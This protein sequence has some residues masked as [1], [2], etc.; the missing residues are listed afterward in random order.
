M[1]VKADLLTEDFKRF[2]NYTHAAWA[3]KFQALVFSY[4]EEQDRTNER[5]RQDAAP[6]SRTHHQLVQGK[7]QFNNGMVEGLN[8]KWNLTVRKAFVFRTFNALQ[9]ASFHQLG[10][11]AEPQL[12]HEFY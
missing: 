3:E 6:P 2:W 11:L 1:T 12:T 5:H 10:D 8:L 4:D 9:M 7:K